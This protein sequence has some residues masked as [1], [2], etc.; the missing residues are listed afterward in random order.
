M[1]SVGTGY[2][3][4]SLVCLLLTGFV[5]PHMPSVGTGYSLYG[6]DFINNTQRGQEFGT[7]FFSYLLGKILCY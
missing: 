7:D 1:P 6:F 2:S 5:K 3:L 4:L